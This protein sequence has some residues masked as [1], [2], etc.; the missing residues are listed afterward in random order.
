MSRRRVASSID[1][2]S[3]PLSFAS[4]VADKTHSVQ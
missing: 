2:N 4:L 3:M 1:H